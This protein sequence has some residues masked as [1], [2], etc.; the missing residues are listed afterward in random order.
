[1]GSRFHDSLASEILLLKR[2]MRSFPF[3]KYECMKKPSQAWAKSRGLGLTM[4]SILLALTLDVCATFTQLHAFPATPPR[5]R[6]TG[7]LV[8]VNEQ[9]RKGLLEDLNV[10]IAR[11]RATLLVDKMQTIGGVGLNRIILQRLFPPLVHVIGPEDLIL[12]LKSAESAD[13]ILTIEGLLYTA[14]R[15]FFVIRVDESEP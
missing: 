9:T 4:T 15:T 10:V 8:P 13:K 7:V 6:F 1:V 11:E 5:V 2:E 3:S 12:R 14:S